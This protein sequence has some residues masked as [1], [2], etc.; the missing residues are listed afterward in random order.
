MTG[1]CLLLGFLPLV[2]FAEWLRDVLNPHW[3]KTAQHF[4]HEAIMRVFYS[5][6]YSFTTWSADII[7]YPL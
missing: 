6:Y 7:R 5:L 2:A 1:I 4:E 3:E